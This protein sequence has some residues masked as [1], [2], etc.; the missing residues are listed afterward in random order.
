MGDG[1]TQF[2]T[3]YMGFG[4]AGP[5]YVLFHEF[6]HHVQFGNDVPFPNSPESTRYTELMADALA[7]YYGHH[8]RGATFQNKRIIDM[9][10]SAYGGGDCEFGAV[11]HHGTPNQRARAVEFATTLID[12][13]KAK[14]HILT[15]LGFIELFNAEFESIIVPDAPP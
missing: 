14:G 1:L 7:A 11:G 2:L 6:G 10:E 9:M 5:E 8:P 12:E 15:S 4:N 13:S 3:E